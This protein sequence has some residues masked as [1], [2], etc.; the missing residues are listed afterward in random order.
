MNQRIV[1]IGLVAALLWPFSSGPAFAVQ[2]ASKNDIL[3]SAAS[4]FEDLTDYALAADRDGMNK[5]LKAYADQAPGVRKVLPA[6]ERAKMDELLAAIKKAESQGDNETVALKS[7]AVYRL[8]VDALDH[9]TLV[10]PVQVA[11]LD[12][13]G[14]M[15]TVLL[16]NESTKD[17]PALANVSAEAIRNWNAIR[18]RVTDK[19]LRDAVDTALAGLVTACTDRNAGMA[20]FAAQIDL[21]LVD[22]LEGYFERP[23][24]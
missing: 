13:A 8:L 20:A 14:F 23:S 9:N 10:V 24:R 2:R 21:A 11:L 5:A 3:L 1:F 16:H 15:V 18:D 4:P 19:G 6:S 12:Y 7:V 17:W 22:L